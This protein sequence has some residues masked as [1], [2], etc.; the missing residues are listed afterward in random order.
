MRVVFDTNIWVSFLIGKRL[1]F[2][3]S[4]F[5]R[6]DIEVYYCFE[7][8]QEFLDVAN[9]VKIKKYVDEKKVREAHR[10]MVNSCRKIQN[11][12]SVDSSIRDPK[13]LYLL[14]LAETVKADVIVT[15]DA[16]LLVLKQH[17]QTKMMTFAEFKAFCSSTFL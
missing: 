16:D 12:E 3:K 11:I 10:I 17:K 7:L 14:S 2:L 1:S 15:G 8:E 13:D 4:C 6:L 9:R 5:E